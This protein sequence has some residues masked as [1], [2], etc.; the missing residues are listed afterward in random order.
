MRRNG[1]CVPLIWYTRF[2]KWLNSFLVQ[3]AMVHSGSSLF[4]VLDMLSVEKEIS[5]DQCLN[6]VIK[7]TNILNLDLSVRTNLRPKRNKNPF[8]FGLKNFLLR[9][10]LRISRAYFKLDKG[11]LSMV[12]WRYWFHSF[13]RKRQ[14]QTRFINFHFKNKLLNNEWILNLSLNFWFLSHL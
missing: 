1:F 10:I 2:S 12:T 7:N 3:P 8:I 6:K 11:C 4:E 13:T 5:L 9:R 14:K